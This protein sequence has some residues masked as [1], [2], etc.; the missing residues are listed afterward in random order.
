M[1]LK[2]ALIT[3]CVGTTLILGTALYT[4]SEC[5]KIFEK[6][7][8]IKE[9]NSI[10]WELK[11]PHPSLENKLKILHD[12]FQNPESEQKYRDL[13]QE[14]EKL[15]QKAETA[16]VQLAHQG[17]KIDFLTQLFKSPESTKKYS[18]ML[19]QYEKLSNTPGLEQAEQELA[20]NIFYGYGSVIAGGLGTFFI[21]M[22]FLKKAKPTGG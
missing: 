15:S 11:S 9:I 16:N 12:V 19:K 8:Q 18:D 21:G 10:R 13:V 20:R 1:T 2:Q 6:H 7:P 4:K 14:Y 5:D 22:H 3:V 17:Y